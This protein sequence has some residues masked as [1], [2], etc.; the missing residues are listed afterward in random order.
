MGSRPFEER[1]AAGADCKPRACSPA[2][3]RNESIRTLSQLTW[4]AMKCWSRDVE[5]E[6]DDHLPERGSTSRGLW[7]AIMGMIWLRD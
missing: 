6:L 2:A 4:A 7:G 3:I 1:G 5:G